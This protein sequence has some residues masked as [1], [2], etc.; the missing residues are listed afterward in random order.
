MVSNQD[1]ARRDPF[2]VFDVRTDRACPRRSH[3]GSHGKLEFLPLSQSASPLVGAA[4]TYQPSQRMRQLR[5][6]PDAADLPAGPTAIAVAPDRVG[7]KE[8]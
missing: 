5:M 6:L 2:E 7:C 1:K 8:V 4:R 3:C